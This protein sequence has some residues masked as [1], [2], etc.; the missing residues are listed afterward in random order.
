M[1]ALSLDV[2]SNLIKDPRS[3]SVDD[4]GNWLIW[5]GISRHVGSFLERGVDGR[6]LL[7]IAADTAWTDLGVIDAEE[8]RVLD[9][10]VEPLSCFQEGDLDD[11]LADALAL[12]AI[13][14]PVAGEVFVVGGGGITGGRHSASNAIVLSENYVS[15]RHFQVSRDRAGQYL[16]QDVGSTTGTFLM[17]REEL[18]LSHEMILQLGT[19]E[20]TVYIVGDSCKLVA[21]EGPDKNA[22]ADVLPQGVSIGR[23]PSNGLCVHDPQTSAFHAEVRRMD[24]G[25]FVLNDKYSTNRTWLRLS[26]DGQPSRRFQLR[27]GDI[28]KVGSTLFL[29]CDPCSIPEPGAS[30]HQLAVGGE[31]GSPP[32]NLATSLAHSHLLPDSLAE[33]LRSIPSYRRDTTQER[34][35]DGSGVAVG[36][37]QIPEGP[38][39]PPLRWEPADGES[40]PVLSREEYA[41]QLTQSRRRM[42]E[43]VGSGQRRV[44][45]GAG[46]NLWDR[47]L[48]SLQ[49]RMRNSRAA[50]AY[51]LQQQHPPSES[52]GER[53]LCK[54][55]YDRETDV[56]LYPCG[57][58]ILCKDC[59]QK[60]S[61]CPVC[62]GVITDVIRTFKS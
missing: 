41:R 51:T 12:H 20:L 4:V 5:L 11:S 24:D 19:T 32:L 23:D 15:R 56:V 58:F 2:P 55:C 49:M 37:G 14:G 30:S 48:S 36:D 39:G 9:S 31:G 59:A 26:P 27:V 38:P 6:R 18:P 61:D 53:D 54:I 17:I 3:W 8:Q 52:V 29:I 10:A 7:A 47:E 62:R 13:E 60:V 42:H 46:G 25:G 34:F 50:M 33:S 16:L 28:F 22:S 45:G 40:R 35:E 44:M 57:H 43:E 21:T 1:P